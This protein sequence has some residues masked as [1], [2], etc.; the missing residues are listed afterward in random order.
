MEADR[1]GTEAEVLFNIIV[2]FLSSN[3][4]G[5]VPWSRFVKS[6]IRIRGVEIKLIRY[7]EDSVWGRSGTQGAGSKHV[8]QVG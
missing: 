1:A 8:N 7:T 6:R 4:P 2:I 3:F 5:L